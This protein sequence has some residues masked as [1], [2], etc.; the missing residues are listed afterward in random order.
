AAAPPHAGPA[1]GGTGILVD[2]AACPFRAF[3]H[4]RLGA[5]AMERP[6]PGLGAPERGQLLH[7]MM[8]NLWRRLKDHATLVETDA[9]ALDAMVREAAGQAVEHVRSRTPGPLEGKFADLERERLAGIAREWLDIERRRAPFEVV[10][11]EEPMQLSAGELQLAGR[12]DRM[13]RLVEGGGLAVIDYKTGS[14]ASPMAWLAPRPDDCQL[15]LYALAAADADIRAIA[16]ARLKVG[17][18]GFA[19]VA[20]EKG[21]LPGLSPQLRSRT[22]DAGPW[23]QMIATWREETAKLGSAYLAAEASVDPKEKLATCERCDLQPLCRVHERIGT[24][25]EGDAEDPD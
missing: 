3:A 22:R 14:N 2:Q 21:L 9:A 18:L 20:R 12:I 16:F 25:D 1:K 17:N 11:I 23:D 19:G 5:K 6:E 4:H 10:K 24:L 13:D 8:A 7:A 15:P